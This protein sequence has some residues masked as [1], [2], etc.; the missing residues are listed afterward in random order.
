[1]KPA[2][3]PAA[4]EC[5]R[6]SKRAFRTLASIAATAWLFAAGAAS[7]ADPA[8][9][10]SI[11]SQGSFFVGG[12]DVSS[13]TLASVPGL[14]PAGT[15][16]VDQMYVHY[17]VPAET[18]DRFPLVLIHGCCLTGKTWETTPD[19]RMGWDEYFLRKNY[20]V[21]VI[22]QASRGRSAFD[23]SAVAGVKLGKL[24]PDQL[25]SLFAASHE[26]AWVVFRFGAAYPQVYPGLQFP[27]DAQNELWK[28]MVP[29]LSEALPKP[30]PTVPDLSLLAKRL[31]GAI[32]ISHSQ[33]GIYPF[34]TAQITPQGMAGI[35]ALEP[36]ACPDP[37]AD[38]RPYAN[39]PIL[40]LYGDYVDGS[41]RWAP[42]LQACRAFVEAARKGGVKAELVLLPDVGIHGNSHMMMQDRNNL[43]VA[44][45]VLGWI[46]RNIGRRH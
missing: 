5:V 32:L 3:D 9:P 41:P 7:A 6:R 22:D 19:N 35:V 40:V 45:W 14:D 43:Q 33:S 13:N 42:R 26:V 16:T 4:K 36:G 1:V 21:Y 39:I 15:V 34:Q 37:H 28:Q 18:G 11:A 27:L 31:N 25:P 38:M 23:P 46:D 2:V 8:S 30:N 17:Q 12:R 10:L 20:P 24:K 29:D 44:D